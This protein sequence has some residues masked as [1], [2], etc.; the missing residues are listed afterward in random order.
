MVRKRGSFRGLESLQ[1]AADYITKVS[2][3][4]DETFYCRT[5]RNSFCMSVKFYVLVD[6]MF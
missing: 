6:F 3:H 5:A 4:T 2:V 1:E